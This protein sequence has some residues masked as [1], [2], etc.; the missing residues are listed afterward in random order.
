MSPTPVAPSPGTLGTLPPLASPESIQNLDIVN[1]CAQADQY[2]L[3]IGRCQS[4]TRHETM[5]ADITRI[6]AMLARFRGRFELFAGQPQLDLPK[7]H[8]TMSAVAKPPI[9]ERIENNDLQH[10]I[11]TLRALRVEIGWSDSGERS[12][13]FSDFDAVRI[14]SV[15]DKLDKEVGEIEKTPSIDLPDINFQLPPAN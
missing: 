5:Q 2:T 3:E 13:G 9:L 4:A 7:Y 15:L 8:P 6:Q 10:V 11:D 1:L 14:R 12:S